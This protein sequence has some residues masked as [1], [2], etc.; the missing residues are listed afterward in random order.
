[1][2]DDPLLQP[3]TLKHLEIR[4]RVFSSAHEPA[5]SHDGMPTERYRLYHAEK[6]KGGVGLTMTAGSAVVSEESPPA[7]GNLHAYKDEIVPWIKEMVDAI[8]EHGAAAMIQISHLGRRT[9]WDHDDWLPIVAPSALREPAHRNIPKEAEDWDIA[10]IVARYADAAERMQAGG[11]DG[12]EVEAYGHLFDQFWSPLTNE[13]AD[14]WGASE[15][16]RLRFPRAVLRAIRERVGDPYIVGLRVA[17]D[18]VT[19]GG[20]DAELGL[21]MLAALRDEGLIDFVNVIRGYIAT[22]AKLIDVIPIH[23]MKSAPHLAFAGEVRTRLGLPVLHAAKIDDVATARYAISEGLLDLVGMTRAQLADPHL[24]RKIMEGRESEIRPC[25]GATY[26]LDRIYAAGEALC[27]H[28]AATSREA[29]MP[30]EISKAQVQKRVVVVGAGPA[31]LEAARVAAERGHNVT[32]LEALP[33]AGGQIQLAARNPRRKD[34]LGIVDWRLAEL[35]RLG[36]DVR[37]NTFAD[38][39]MVASL[40]PGVVIVATGG[41][42]QIPRIE[43]GAE[44][45]VTSWDVLGGDV[46]LSGDVMLFDDNGTHSAMSAAEMLARS[47]CSVEIVTPERALGI[48]VGG[49]NM[50]PYIAAFNESE[51]LITLNHRVIKVRRRDGDHRLEVTLGSDHTDHRVVRV[52]DHVVADHGTA[53]N[54]GIYHDLRPASSNGGEVDQ[55]ALISGLPQSV[56]RNEI[57]SFKLFRIGDAVAGRN[58]HAAVYDGLRYMFVI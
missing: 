17:V 58:I 48:D 15:E 13:R 44:L 39:D 34:L 23:G 47:G 55:L 25:V 7:F 54:A 37:Y 22:D 2:S 51:T 5:Y 14:D 42:P 4:N 53:V 18:E 49:L 10:R 52:V 9:G 56:V 24:V 27:I 36:A 33:V 38:A 45:L 35:R 6:A 21:T 28:N 16:T 46:R 8:H 31:G 30:H 41:L 20:V 32:V 19:P 50:V 11:M 12:I 40:D 26:C 3:F 57:G 43:S 29:T 1:M